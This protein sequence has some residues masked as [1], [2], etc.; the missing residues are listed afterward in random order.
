MLASRFARQLPVKQAFRAFSD[1]KPRKFDANEAVD[2]RW[3]I[4]VGAG[5]FGAGGGL[6]L[7]FGLWGCEKKTKTADRTRSK[8]SSWATSDLFVE[9]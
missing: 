7:R 4:I 6:L 5:M 2:M 8:L 1:K 3:K 9:E